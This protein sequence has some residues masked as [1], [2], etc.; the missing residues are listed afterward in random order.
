MLMIETIYTVINIIFSWFSL[1]GTPSFLSYE[2]TDNSQGNFYIF[3][4]RTTNGKM[5]IFCSKFTQ[6]VLTT[7]LEAPYFNIKGIRVVNTVLQVE[8]MSYLAPLC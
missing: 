7:S 6:V 2:V 1:V 5:N 3:F 8:Y 4:V